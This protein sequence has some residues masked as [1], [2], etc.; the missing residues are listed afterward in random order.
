MIQSRAVTTAVSP[1]TRTTWVPGSSSW[2]SYW[3][4]FVAG[5]LEVVFP[6]DDAAVAEHEDHRL[7]QDP[8]DRRD[9]VVL[10]RGLEFGVERRDRLA[11]LF[12]RS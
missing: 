10:H 11:V 1:A 7:V 3:I 5:R 12:G 8:V 9:I 6:R 4:A 2:T